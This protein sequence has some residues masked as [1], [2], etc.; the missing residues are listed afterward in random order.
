MAW[1]DAQRFGCR[2][3][4]ETVFG[5]LVR[6][7][8]RN[9]GNRL[10]PSAERPLCAAAW[11]RVGGLRFSESARMRRLRLRLEVR[12]VAVAASGASDIAPLLCAKGDSVKDQQSPKRDHGD[13]GR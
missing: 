4:T 2:V 13:G 11:A 1:S 12:R 8:L 3:V 10:Q 6:V 5:D 7:D 9:P